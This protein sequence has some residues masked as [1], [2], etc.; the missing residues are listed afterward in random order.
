MTV[1]FAK[2]VE[3]HGNRYRRSHLEIASILCC[4]SMSSR[5]VTMVANAIPIFLHNEILVAD[6]ADVHVITIGFAF[7]F[8]S[9]DGGRLEVDFLVCSFFVFA[10]VRSYPS[11]ASP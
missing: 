6:L 10:R 2:I 11:M 4:T 7:C 3:D 9:N 8:E 5:N 1:V